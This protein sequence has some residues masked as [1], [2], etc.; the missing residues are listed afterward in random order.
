MVAGGGLKTGIDIAKC[1]ALG[2]DVASLA[3]AMLHA[4]AKSPEALRE[5]IRILRQQL[6]IAMFATGSTRLSDLRT[7][8]LI[9]A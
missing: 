7:A 6:V 9:I 5:R 2:A 4:A 3:G 8:E 1:I